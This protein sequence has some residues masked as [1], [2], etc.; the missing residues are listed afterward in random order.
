MIRNKIFT[1]VEVIK[2]ILAD[3]PTIKGMYFHP[4]V[5]S[6]KLQSRISLNSIDN[7]HF[8][9][10]MALRNRYS[11]PFWDSIMLSFYDKKHISKKILSSVLYHSKRNKVGIPRQYILDD[12]LKEILS[13]GINYAVNSRVITGGTKK[14]HIPLLDFK[15][16][17]SKENQI[18]VENVLSLLSLNSG[19]ILVSGKSY[20]FIG[21]SLIT[22]DELISLLAKAILF[23]PII[24][25]NWLAH[26][27][28]DRSC[29]LRFTSK[30]GILPRLIKICNS[31]EFE[32]TH[33]LAN[34]RV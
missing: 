15:I 1:T 17:E 26:Q 29:S 10:A 28:I 8:G 7:A 25:K 2:M 9:D 18:V 19:Y 3:H 6:P 30:Y 16:P 5:S 14:Y 4:F 31:T 13:L 33:R 27:L 24:D 20:H 32:K 21:S 12:E 11:L 23:S 34:R 22:E